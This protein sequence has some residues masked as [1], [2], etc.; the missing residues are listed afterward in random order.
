M[1]IQRPV[2]H[3]LR[4]FPSGIS[5]ELC[6][7]VLPRSAL[8]YVESNWRVVVC[9]VGLNKMPGVLTVLRRC[10]SQCPHSILSAMKC[11]ETETQKHV[12]ESAR[13]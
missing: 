12:S 11:V 1:M 6:R 5:S 8:H 9:F 4:R 3:I 10:S 7:E 13:P 2:T